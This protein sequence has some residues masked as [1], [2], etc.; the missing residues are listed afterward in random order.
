MCLTPTKSRCRAFPRSQLQPFVE[1]LVDDSVTPTIEGR[2]RRADETKLEMWLLG[3]ACASAVVLTVGLFPE[4]TPVEIAAEI[5]RREAFDG[6]RAAFAEDCLVALS[7]GR[8]VNTTRL[9]RADDHQL[10]AGLM[11]VTA[12]LAKLS[13]DRLPNSA[14]EVARVC[15]RSADGLLD[16]VS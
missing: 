11:H 15:F 3:R 13:A 2:T 8:E 5:S 7:K 12:G 4:L 14:L 10:M 16:R 9:I 6:F 1:A